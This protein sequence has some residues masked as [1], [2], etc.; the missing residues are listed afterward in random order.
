M[1]YLHHQKLCHFDLKLGNV[2]ISDSGV[3][4]I[5]DFGSLICTEGATKNYFSPFTYRA[6]EAL[7]KDGTKAIVDGF[8][9]DVQTLGILAIELFAILEKK[10]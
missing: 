4:V 8:K 10:V 5:N 6:P 7:I 9:Y 2:M 3:A 1:K